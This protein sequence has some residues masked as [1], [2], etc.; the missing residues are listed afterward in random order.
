M[1][2]ERSV[3][4]RPWQLNGKGHEA[5]NKFLELL[6]ELL[7]FWT[8]LQPDQTPDQD[9]KHYLLAQKVQSHYSIAATSI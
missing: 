9:L 7:H 8:W 2:L 1:Y 5:N 4:P 6:L 3:E